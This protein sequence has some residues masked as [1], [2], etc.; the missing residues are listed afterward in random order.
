MKLFLDSTNNKK[1]TIRLDGEEFANEYASPQEQDV[2]LFLNSL[3]EKKGKSLDG[4]SEIE[5]N[6]GPGSFTGSRVGVTI[7]NTLAFALHLKVNGKTPPILPIYA[8]PP[9]ISAPKTTIDAAHH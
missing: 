7:A 3:L 2:L 4:V 9:N 6:P 5:V 8:A 1:V